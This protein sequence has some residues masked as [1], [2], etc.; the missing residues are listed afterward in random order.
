MN[1]LSAVGQIRHFEIFAFT[2]YRDFKTRFTGHPK[3]QAM[4]PLNRSHIMTSVTLALSCTVL[5]HD[6]I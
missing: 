2:K 1:E 3:S 5:R 4:T 6:V